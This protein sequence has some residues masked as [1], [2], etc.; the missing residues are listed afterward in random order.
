[1]LENRSWGEPIKPSNPEITSMSELAGV[2]L[3]ELP[4]FVLV[5]DMRVTSETQDVAAGLI[6]SL[7]LDPLFVPGVV[8][9]YA[10]ALFSSATPET[11]DFSGNVIKLDEADRDPLNHTNYRGMIKTAIK[12]KVPVHG[13]DSDRPTASA[14]DGVAEDLKGE[15]IKGPEPMKVVLVNFGHMR[16][17]LTDPHDLISRLGHKQCVILNEKIYIPPDHSQVT[18][19]DIFPSTRQKYNIAKYNSDPPYSPIRQIFVRF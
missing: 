10:E 5:G 15:I 7:A 8:G 1:M 2:L 18:K 19:A 9:L 14:A 6:E 16:N 17:T 12:S 4:D 11:G 3:E 13:I